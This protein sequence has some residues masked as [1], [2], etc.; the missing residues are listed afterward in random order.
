MAKKE[1]ITIYTN[2]NCDYCKQLKEELD[3]NNIEYTDIDT[4]KYVK[5]WQNV[6]DTTFIPTVPTVLYK[7]TYFVAGRDFANP[8]VLMKLLNEF[9]GFDYNDPKLTLERIRTLTYSMTL[10]FGRVD[11]ILR[12]IENQ[13]KKE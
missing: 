9:E 4:V 12:N 1:K 2:N 8:S 3:K 11:N 5:V 13:L 10:A 6:V 7:D